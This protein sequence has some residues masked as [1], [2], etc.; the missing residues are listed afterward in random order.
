MSSSHH[1]FAGKTNRLNS[2][3]GTDRNE[4]KVLKDFVDEVNKY[5]Q[6][7]K[8]Q[9][10]LAESHKDKAQDKDKDSLH[11]RGLPET[12]SP[13]PVTREDIIVLLKMIRNIED[14][15]ASFTSPSSKDGGEEEEGEEKEEE[16]EEDSGSEAD[17][18]VDV[19]VKRLEGWETGAGK[20]QQM[21]ESLLGKE[22]GSSYAGLLCGCERESGW[23]G[24]GKLKECQ[25]K[26]EERL[27]AAAE[28]RMMNDYAVCDN[29]GGIGGRGEDGVCW[30]R[31][32]WKEVKKRGKWEEVEKEKEKED[33]NNLKGNEEEKKG[34]KA[35]ERVVTEYHHRWCY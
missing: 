7:Q 29:G 12:I 20:G 27:Y 4:G 34:K 3:A 26:V 18:D 33:E 8:E 14:K 22:M 31:W 15:L 1:S 13:S 16:M 6:R 35:P 17:V 30:G 28:R 5:Q 23:Y 32:E 24:C 21:G 25:R 19:E 10:S 9:Q 11:R 2:P